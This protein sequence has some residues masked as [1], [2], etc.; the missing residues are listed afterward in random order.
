MR[1]LLAHENSEM[2]GRRRR[3]RR[4]FG[5]NVFPTAGFGLKTLFTLVILTSGAMSVSFA[6]EGSAGNGRGTAAQEYPVIVPNSSVS[7][8][9]SILENRRPEN[10]FPPDSAGKK[11]P[12]PTVSTPASVSGSIS[13]PRVLPSSPTPKYTPVLP[14]RNPYPVK[15]SGASSSKR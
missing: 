14:S 8:G 3:R 6:G 12:L 5:M 11:S 1:I 10:N 13:S 7:P 15:A 2:E 9:V 4:M